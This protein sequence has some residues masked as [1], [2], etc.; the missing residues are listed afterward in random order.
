[1]VD[2]LIKV[3]CLAILP[4]KVLINIESMIQDYLSE[5]DNPMFGGNRVHMEMEHEASQELVQ[6][7][8]LAEIELAQW[9]ES[10]P[11]DKETAKAL[12]LIS[13]ELVKTEGV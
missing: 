13:A 8:Y 6:A 7:L 3:P 9:N 1:M 5:L 10:N 12:K 2:Y 11:D 4:A